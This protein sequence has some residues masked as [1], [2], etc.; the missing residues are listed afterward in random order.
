MTTPEMALAFNFFGT[1]I[2]I[3]HFSAFSMRVRET[4]LT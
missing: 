2:N 4:V 1:L 3:I